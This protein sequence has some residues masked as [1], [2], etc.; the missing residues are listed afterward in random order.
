MS[1]HTT[2]GTEGSGA[3]LEKAETHDPSENK[4]AEEEPVALRDEQV[5]APAPELSREVYSGVDERSGKNSGQ[6]V[7]EEEVGAKEPKEPMDESDV[8]YKRLE[9]MTAQADGKGHARE[10]EGC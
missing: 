7:T 9:E 4:K 6:E 8:S 10:E 5:S 2:A 1:Q 3:T